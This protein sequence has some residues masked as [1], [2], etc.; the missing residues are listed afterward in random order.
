M[1][2]SSNITTVLCLFHTN[3]QAQAAI[4]ELKQSEV[5]ANSIVVLDR[6]AN[7]SG[8]RSD[9]TALQ[10]LGLPA[11]DLS[12]LS[13]GI[14]SG[15]T[16]IVVS[17]QD[18]MTNKAESI[19]GRHQAR[20]VDEKIVDDKAEPI[21]QTGNGDAVIPIMEE[22]LAIGKREV[23]RGGVRVYSR[24]VE[25]PVEETVILREEHATVERRPVNR[26]VSE[27]DLEALRIQSVEVTETVEVPVVEK[28]ARVVEEVMVSKE[29]SERTEQISD[30]V[31]KTQVEV[32]KIETD[33]KSSRKKAVKN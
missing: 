18:S 31:R 6:G 3:E 5:P 27:A 14:S 10:Q 7:S 15:G 1:E 19:F 12:L 16:V 4:A 23:Q 25:T 20:K 33:A 30:S 17:G 29:S 11:R 28:S 9:T 22:E 32:E 26:A 24:V 2:A 8:G 13:E 21:A